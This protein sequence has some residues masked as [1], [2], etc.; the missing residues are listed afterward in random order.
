MNQAII[1]N[2]QK[3]GTVAEVSLELIEGRKCPECGGILIEARLSLPDLYIRAEVCNLC[4]YE[5][6]TER[7]EQNIKEES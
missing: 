4:E 6:V 5:L 1:E 7:I 3:G 2:R